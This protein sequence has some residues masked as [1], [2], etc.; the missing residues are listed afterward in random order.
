MPLPS[1]T[2]LIEENAL[3]NQRIREL[4]KSETERKRAEKLL[5]QS[6]EKYR[7]LA[8]NISE[9]V[10]IMDLKLNITYISPS[11]EKLYGYTSDEIKK[12]SMKT[13]FTVESYQKI[14][15]VYSRKL[16]LATGNPPMTPSEGRQVMELEAYHKDGHKLWTENRV[17][18]IR[19]ENGNPTSILGETRDITDRKLAQELLKK[20]EERY[21]TI[22]EDIQ[23]GYFEVDLAGNFTFFNET[24]CR[25]SGYSRKELMG[26]NNRQYTD[27]EEQKRVYEAYHKV[28]TTGEPLRELVWRIKTKDGVTKYIQG[29]ISLIKDPTGQPTGFRGIARDITERKETDE[30]L[31]ENEKRLY[32]ITTHIPGVVFRFYAMDS[33]EYGI[34]YVSERVSDIFEVPF[35]TELDSLFP[36]FFSHIHK[37]DLDRFTAS[38]Q[39]A[40]KEN[41]PWDF[42]GR[43]IKPSGNMF[44][45]R[46]MSTPTRHDDR[47]VFDGILLDITA[48]KQAE[49]A[50]RESE[51]LY[52]QLVDTIPDIVVRTDLVGRILFAND[53]V[54][55]IGGYRMEEVQGRNILDFVSPEDHDRVTRNIIRIMEEKKQGPYEYHLVT[56]DGSRIPYEIISGIFHVEDGTPCGLVHVCRNISQRKQ[57]ELEKE[58]LQERL[59]QA[60]KMESV[61]RLA[62]GVAHDFNNMLSVILGHTELAM[63]DA[64]SDQPLYAHLLE[65]RKAAERSADLTRQL[66]AF[67]RKQTVSPRVIDMNQTVEGMLKMLQRLIGEDIHLDW[68]PCMNSWP[69]KVDP[70][71]VDQILANLCVNAR[72]AITGV[73][74]I[75]IE[76]GNIHIDEAFCAGHPYLITTG[77]YILLAVSDDGH[78]MD[79]EVQNRLFEP[80]FTTKDIGKGTGLGLS[81]VYGIVKQNKGFINVYSEPGQ[82]TTFRIYLP[83]YTG[84][85]E[86]T[87]T[88]QPQGSMTGG[89]ET[90]LVVED[91]SSILDLCKIMLEQQGYEVLA[92]ATPT[93]AIELAG[94]HSGEIHL[95]ITD[96][97]MPGMNGRDLAKRFLSIYPDMKCL[98]MSGYTPNMIAHQGILDEGVYFIQKPFSKN[99]LTTRVREILDQK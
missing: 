53:N 44:W 5:R 10:W 14:I 27:Q 20:S 63:G 64:E 74:K 54:I 61:G 55:R 32:G 73:G 22:L 50:L 18:F 79:R 81:T 78:G 92:A 47:I 83:R 94:G 88:E 23:E 42:E 95:L 36:I 51:G 30:L 21:R 57:A 71:Q 67:A 58:Q 12:L 43:Y 91:E 38:V 49:E 66:L 41:A 25:V 97:V 93:E 17:S 4:E 34:S 11:V 85:A 76:L 70:S 96:M 7:L 90:V 75:S 31:Q 62:G 99:D 29:S 72:D 82:G 59:N 98:F 69:V 16:S 9:H 84:A 56:K 2:K 13:F 37:E 19:D 39:I 24:L 80:F 1:K 8:D 33:G 26:M 15:E 65:I 48:R 40:V 77:D 87:K 35:E 28:Y 68:Q 46:A 3:L 45:F 86:Q 52:I 89:H 6:E 60:Q